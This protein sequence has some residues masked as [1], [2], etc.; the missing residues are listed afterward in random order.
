MRDPSGMCTRSSPYQARVVGLLESSLAAMPGIG[1]L[2]GGALT[3][4]GSPRTAYAVA[5]AGTLLFVFVATVRLRHTRL[6]R[7]RRRQQDAP[8]PATS[9]LHPPADPHEVSLEA[10][11]SR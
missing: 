9:H 1:Y 3:A 4:A 8:P 10:G 5:V 2:V 11:E 6:D 7:P